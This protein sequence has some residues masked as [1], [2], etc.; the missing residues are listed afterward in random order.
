VAF[1]HAWSL[2]DP[3]YDLSVVPFVDE[4][5]AG[6]GDLYDARHYYLKNVYPAASLQRQ[7][8][9]VAAGSDA[10]V[11]D[12]D[13]RPFFNMEQAVTRANDAIGDGVVLNA[14]ERLSIHDV[15]A[16]YTIHG[17]RSL[18]AD[19]RQGSIEVGKRADLVVLDRDVVALADSGRADRI[20][21]TQVLTTM[22]DGRVVFQRA[23]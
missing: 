21:E 16:A 1:T 18:G 11:D 12:R 15:L 22:F 13:P 6:A 3:V 14:A 17:A 2:P 10:P 5:E 23:P 19:D 8:G 20:S 4:L 9:I 7:G